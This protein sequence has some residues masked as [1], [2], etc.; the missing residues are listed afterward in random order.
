MSK[1]SLSKIAIFF[2][3]FFRPAVFHP[4]LPSTI[5]LIPYMAVLLLKT[6]TLFR[7]LTLLGPSLFFLIFLSAWSLT[8]DIHTNAIFDMGLRS[9]FATVIRFIL[10]I[11]IAYALVFFVTKSLNDLIYYVLLTVY[12]Q[13][14]LAIAMILMPDLKVFFYKSLSGYTGSE[15][16]F[17]EYFLNVRAFGW[18]EEL[19]FT[20]P[21]MMLS[22]FIIFSGSF[23]RSFIPRFILV[24]IS[25]I[26]NAR[27][28]LVSLILLSG[29]VKSL[30]DLLMITAIILFFG[31]LGIYVVR[32]VEGIYVI[33]KYLLS[34]FKNG[35]SYVVK[36]LI[37]NHLIWPQD[38][39][40]Y[41]FGKNVYYYG[42]SAQKTSDIG[43]VIISMYG[44]YIYLASWSF[45]LV[46]LIIKNCCSGRLKILLIFIT[47][48]LSFKGL[49]FSGNA[50]IML[51]LILY[52]INIK[53]GKL[54]KFTHP[55]S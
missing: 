49:I 19:F 50:V 36:Y 23:R 30:R 33:L 28:S 51:L 46:Y 25:S 29:R 40:Q 11:Y 45:L 35:G 37:E 21:V 55:V 53:Y 12:I 4:S 20:A 10:Y 47:F 38:T 17:R 48:L 43:F 34:D 6:R 41:L 7:P 14:F 26:V 52:F 18:S 5:F 15:K 32:Y 3:A 42:E 1:M 22:A 27:V 44:G 31:I 13:C 2:I 9:Q 8:I 39:L 54:Y 16:I 24:F